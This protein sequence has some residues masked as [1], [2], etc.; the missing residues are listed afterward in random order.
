MDN[1]DQVIRQFVMRLVQVYLQHFYAS[2]TSGNAYSDREL[3]PNFELKFLCADMFP[4]ED[5][6]TVSVCPYPEKRIHLN[7]VNVSPTLVIDTSMESSSR[8]LHHEHPKIWFSFLKSLNLI[9]NCILAYAK[10]LSI[11]IYQSYSS[12]WYIN[13]RSI[14]VLHHGNAK[15]LF[16]IFFSKK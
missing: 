4:Y 8:V 1:I 5:S 16:L 2:P 6:K 12:K 14:K 3:T 11:T 9:L 10:S 13:E 15:I 7:F